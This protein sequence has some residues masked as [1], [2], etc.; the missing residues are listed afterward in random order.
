MLGNEI[1][2]IRQGRS[3][4]YGTEQDDE[5]VVFEDHELA[6]IRRQFYNF[7]DGD[8][9]LIQCKDITSVMNAANMNPNA[10]EIQDLLTQLRVTS[11]TEISFAELIDI[12]A[13][14]LQRD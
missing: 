7:A 11:D 5:L 9:G 12:M 1:A 4:Q 14:T 6:T 10:D 3:L 8:S 2:R 13:L